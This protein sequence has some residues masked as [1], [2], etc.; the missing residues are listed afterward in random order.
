MKYRQIGNLTTSA[1]GLGCMGMSEFY[2][3]TNEKE[4]IDVIHHAFDQ[5]VTMFDTADVYGMGDNEKLL[6]KSLKSVRK[7]AIIATKFGILRD[8]ND[9]LFRGIDGRP[10]YV[11]RS[12]DQSLKLLGTDYIDL[13]YLHRVDPNVP[14]EE[15]VGAISELVAAGKVRHIGLSE[16]S[17][18]TIRRA[19]AVHPITAVQTEYS[20]GTND[21][22]ENGI[23]DTT[24]ELNIGLVAYSPLCRA[25]LTGKMPI[26]NFEDGDFR[27]NMPRFTD[28]H[29]QQNLLLVEALSDIAATKN[30]SLAQLSLAWLLAQSDNIVPIPGTK[31]LKYLNDNLGALNVTLT[32][33]ELEAINHAMAE[34]KLSGDR[35]PT[36]IIN[37]H[38]L[39]G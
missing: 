22:V 20:I 30:C 14:I 27:Q 19:N 7:K 21:V 6:G 12:C 33:K 32:N 3:A 29:S 5:G 4:A 39:N 9:P 35:Y 2:G 23:L 24:K 15:T 10:A 31:R 34:N 18:E 26:G 13:Y 1:L 36:E 25:L 16:A 17:A 11:H 28:E 38:N 37:D 8:P